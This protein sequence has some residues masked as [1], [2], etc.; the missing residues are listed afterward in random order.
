MTIRVSTQ[1]GDIQAPVDDP[2][3]EQSAQTE[4]AAEIL[5][6]VIGPLCNRITDDNPKASPDTGR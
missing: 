2:V 3:S 5:E 4:G 1:L 6:S